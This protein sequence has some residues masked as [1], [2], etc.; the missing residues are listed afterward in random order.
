M[1]GYSLPQYVDLPVLLTCSEWV[2]SLCVDL[3]VLLTCSEC[4]FFLCVDL[5]VLLTCS[6]WVSSLCVDLAVL[7]TCSEWVSSLCVDLAVLLTCSEC[8]FFLCVLTWQC[9]WPVLSGYP[10]CVLTWQCCWPVLSGYPLPV[11]WLGSVIDLF[12]VGILFMWVYLCVLT[13]QYCWPVLSVY[14]LPMCWLGSVIDLFWVGILFL[15]VLTCQWCLPIL[16]CCPALNGYSLRCWL[17]LNGYHHP[18][19]VILLFLTCFELVS[20][21]RFCWSHGLPHPKCWL[22]IVID[23][24]CM[25]VLTCSCSCS[26]LHGHV[27]LATVHSISAFSVKWQCFVCVCVCYQGKQWSD[28]NMCALQMFFKDP[29]SFDIRVDPSVCLFQFLCF[30]YPVFKSD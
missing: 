24:I 18:L 1:N 8:I 6:E 12:W 29:V 15:C 30:R 20:F 17:V 2:S 3:A 25:W 9:C 16:N 22:T 28:W 13:W 11:C 23:M 7:L 14:P 5:A 21:C 19:S 4:I 27:C 10:L 26:V